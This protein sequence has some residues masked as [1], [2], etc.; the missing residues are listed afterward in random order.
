[1]KRLKKDLNLDARN[2]TGQTVAQIID[3]AIIANTAVIPELSHAHLS[4]GG[5]VILFGNLAPEGAVVKQSAVSKDMLVFTGKARVFDSEADCLAAI[6]ENSLNEGEIVVIRYE[7]PKGG[8][9]M[10]EMLAVTMA[11]E[12]YGKKKTALI[13]DGRFSGATAGPCVGRSMRKMVP[14]RS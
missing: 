5:T 8:P 6:R 2:V 10:P 13:T 12:L 7:G 11:L 4:E 9:G 14:R 3:D 1:M